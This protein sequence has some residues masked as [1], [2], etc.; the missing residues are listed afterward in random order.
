MHPDE[1]ERHFAAMLDEAGLP[2]FTAERDEHWSRPPR[3]CA[4]AGSVSDYG[5]VVARVNVSVLL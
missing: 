5:L 2:R 3:G 4:A 1:V